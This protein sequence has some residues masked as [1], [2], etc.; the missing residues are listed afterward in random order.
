ML[1]SKEQ[2][3]S[4]DF[5]FKMNVIIFLFFFII[6][7][8]AKLIIVSDIDDTIKKT[9][10][11]SLGTLKDFL[12]DETYPYEEMQV[13]Y[14]ELENLGAD[15]FYLSSSYKF[16][17]NANNWLEE[18]NFP[19]GKVVQRNEDSP[20]DG[21]FFKQKELKEFLISENL[22]P[23]DSILFFGDNLGQDDEVYANVVKELKLSSQSRIYIRDIT[24]NQFLP[25]L[26]LKSAPIEE[27]RYFLSENDFN[28][29]YFWELF[30]AIDLEKIFFISG[31]YY[32][33]TNLNEFQKDL[34]RKRI[35][36]LHCRYSDFSCQRKISSRYYQLLNEY[37]S[38]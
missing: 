1:E 12:K 18:Q 25:A 4:F 27:V 32:K 10:G 28:D 31:S 17:Y 6:S 26:E 15:F 21:K 5:G 8:Q 23:D 38:Y 16:I 35:L 30:G 20:F 33:K 7:A 37:Y 14:K 3:S 29:L 22:S 19:E 11:L 36:N 13:L 2:L 9:Q 34:L 24:M